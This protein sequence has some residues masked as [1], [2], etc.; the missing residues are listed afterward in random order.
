MKPTE[1]GLMIIEI[2]P[3]IDIQKDILDQMDFAPLISEDVIEMDPR[4]FREETMNLR[5]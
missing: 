1:K 4:I 3:G 5:A 2:A